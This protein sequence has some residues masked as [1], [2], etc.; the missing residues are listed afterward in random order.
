MVFTTYFTNFNHLI[1]EYDR[2][3]LSLWDSQKE[4]VSIVV[5][6]S[7]SIV[8]ADLVCDFLMGVQAHVWSKY[9]AAGSFSVADKDQGNRMHRGLL[10]VLLV[11]QCSYAAAAVT[12]ELTDLMKLPTAYAG[13]T[14]CKRSVPSGSMAFSYHVR[15]RPFPALH[16]ALT[17]LLCRSPEQRRG[18]EWT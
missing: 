14:V 16:L 10:A 12:I 2:N 3:L 4:S 6:E 8:V 17:N 15:C 9:G 11:A 5:K 18:R 7:L 1:Y 13:D